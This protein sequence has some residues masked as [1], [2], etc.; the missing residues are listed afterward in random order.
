MIHDHPH[1]PNERSLLVFSSEK[2]A[3]SYV[4]Q[5][6]KVG[7][8]EYE[9]KSIESLVNLVVPRML[10]DDIRLLLVNMTRQIDGMGICIPLRST[11]QNIVLE[12]NDGMAAFRRNLPQA[13]EDLLWFS[14]TEEYY[15]VRPPTQAEAQESICTEKS[16]VLVVAEDGGPPLRLAFNREYDDL[17]T[18]DWAALAE[19]VREKVDH[20]RLDDETDECVNTIQAFLIRK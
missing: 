1:D 3:R 14:Q 20:E 18:V 6:P 2:K 15:R 17:E 5:S 13:E 11:F 16:L 12:F 10:D 7:D 9:R 8:T 19:T 4:E